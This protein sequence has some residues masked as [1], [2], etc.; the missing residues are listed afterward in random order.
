MK[1]KLKKQ[2]VLNYDGK[3][4]TAID[5]L[6]KMDRKN[7]GVQG[8]GIGVKFSDF[9]NMFKPGKKDISKIEVI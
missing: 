7:I 2:I 6:L 9:P 5:D 1:S 8:I 4:F 3:S